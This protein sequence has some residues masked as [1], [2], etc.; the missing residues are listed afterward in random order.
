MILLVHGMFM[1]DKMITIF[2]KKNIVLP[3]KIEIKQYKN[4]RITT[5][6]KHTHKTKDTRLSI[7][8]AHTHI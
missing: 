5:T 1:I 7:H 6:S 8:H 2:K 3:L 4:E